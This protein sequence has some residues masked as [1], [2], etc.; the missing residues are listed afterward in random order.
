M[1]Y[2]LIIG[3][4]MADNPVKA[5]SGKTPLE[6]ADKPC[7]DGLASKSRLGS[8]RTVPEGFPPGSDTAIMGIF[9]CSAAKYYSGRAPLEAAAQG[10]SLE[11]GD[12]AYRCNNVCLSDG[13]PFPERTILSHS[14]GGIGGEDGM[15]LAR[16][17]FNDPE[18]KPLAEKAGMA[19]YPT[20]SY[21][22]IA[23][24][25]N[26]N[27]KGLKL[28]PPH[29]HIGEKVGDNLPSGCE[30]AEVLTHLMAKANEI[31]DR[32][33][34]NEARRKAGNMPA[35]A[36]WFWAEGTAAALPNFKG[37]YG[38]TG[39]VVSAVPLCHGIA[40]MIGLDVILVEGATGELDTNYEGK[41]SAALEALKTHDFVAVHLEAPDEC[42]HNGDL[43]GKLQAIE[44]LD[45]RIV[46]PIV[47]SMEKSGE[48]FRILILSDHKTLLDGRCHDGDPVPYLIYD[49][50]TDTGV[51]LEYTE[52][53]CLKGDLIPQATDLMPR[54]FEL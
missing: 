2:I 22:H 34:M 20:S 21:R 53:N 15:S 32:H 42:S 23:V 19:I 25:K 24:Q 3:D 51:N 1:K 48:D 10:I 17:L 33:P 6:Y 39:A 12:A 49:S 29:D 5:L 16:Q 30:N 52:K 4:G 28:S 45:G 18:F 11:P 38:K 40:R 37:Q 46:K 54:L 14:A 9:G 41:V 50:R 47:D 7:I 26:V 43:E 13:V 44:R 36:I 31:L 27:I 35:N 8:A